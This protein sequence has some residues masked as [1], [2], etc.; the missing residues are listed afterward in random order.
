[1]GVGNR[2]GEGGLERPLGV[3]VGVEVGVGVGQGVGVM[4]V[5]GEGNEG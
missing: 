4:R 3:E 2:R 1:M 5:G